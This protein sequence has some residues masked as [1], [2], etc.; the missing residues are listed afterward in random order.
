MLNETLV[1]A[2][3]AILSPAPAKAA[4]T[5]SAPV[6]T[7]Q[8][9]AV[10]Q[11]KLYGSQLM[12]ADERNVYRDKMKQAKTPA[13]RD[14]LRQEHQRDMQQRAKDRGVTLPQQPGS[15][16]KQARSQQAANAASVR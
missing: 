10:A 3:L 9:K 1:A 8:K 14:R 6:A 7:V 11:D 16:T 13:E 12:T 4:D 2:F 5:P 15:R